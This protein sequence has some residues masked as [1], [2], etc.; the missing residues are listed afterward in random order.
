MSTPQ[1]TAASGPPTTASDALRA[2]IPPRADRP[3]LNRRYGVLGGTRR[4]TVD[5]LGRDNTT[6]ACRGARP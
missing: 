5:A 2:D 4:R 3:R 1:A 6:R